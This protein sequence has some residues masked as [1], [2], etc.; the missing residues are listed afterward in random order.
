ML[1]DT[2]KRGGNVQGVTLVTLKTEDVF[3]GQNK[4]R[5]PASAFFIIEYDAQVLYGF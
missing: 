3:P 1:F 5:A 4:C 2:S